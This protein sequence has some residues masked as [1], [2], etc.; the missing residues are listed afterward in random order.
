VA[1]T[2]NEMVDIAVKDMP[3]VPD[4]V[5][6]VVIV[7]LPPV[8][9]VT[10]TVTLVDKVVPRVTFVGTGAQCMAQLC[11]CMIYIYI[12]IYIIVSCKIP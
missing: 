3:L 8:A 1:H 9:L 4:V 2:T 12:Y 6:C 7:A 5:F 11:H 10:P